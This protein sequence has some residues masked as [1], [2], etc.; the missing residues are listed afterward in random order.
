[1]YLLSGSLQPCTQTSS[2]AVFKFQRQAVEFGDVFGDG[3]TQSAALGILSGRTVET[4]FNPRQVFGGDAGALVTYF[5]T[6]SVKI[7]SNLAV[8]GRI[9]H[10]VVEQVAQHELQ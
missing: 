5:D 7:Q 9:A 2:V 1:M 4:F 6:V 8:F 3:Q 10:S